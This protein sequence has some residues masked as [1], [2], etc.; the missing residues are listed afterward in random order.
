MKGVILILC[1][2][3]CEKNLPKY[4]KMCLSIKNRKKVKPVIPNTSLTLRRLG[5]SKGLICNQ[6]VGGSNPSVGSIKIK[7]AIHMECPFL[8]ESSFCNLNNHR[9][10]ISQLSE[11]MD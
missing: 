5:S 3:L 6:R 9:I 7:G 8:I 11:S 1:G 10:F 2:N 4:A